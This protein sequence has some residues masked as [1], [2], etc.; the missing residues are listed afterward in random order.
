MM[1]ISLISNPDTVLAVFYDQ[2]I[3]ILS[4]VCFDNGDKTTKVTLKRQKSITPATP[5]TNL[6]QWYT[7]FPIQN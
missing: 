5:Y 2:T 1:V 3:K 7:C 4:I 6:V